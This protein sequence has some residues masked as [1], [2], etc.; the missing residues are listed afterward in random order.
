[1]TGGYPQGTDDL[2]PNLTGSIEF[3]H[4]SI[5]NGEACSSFA[6]ELKIFIVLIPFD[7]S[8][9]W[10]QWCPKCMWEEVA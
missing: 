1:M 8:K 7:I 9:L 2:K 10:L 3:G 4:S 5:Y 6:P